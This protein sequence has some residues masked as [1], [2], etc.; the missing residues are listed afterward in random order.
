MLGWE[1]WSAQTQLVLNHGVLTSVTTVVAP[2]ITLAY[3]LVETGST[4]NA[5]ASLNLTLVAPQLSLATCSLVVLVLSAKVVP[6][7]FPN[8][9]LTTVRTGELCQSKPTL[10]EPEFG[11]EWTTYTTTVQTQ[12]LQR[13]SSSSS[14]PP[15]GTLKSLT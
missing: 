10:L 2:A 11:V 12:L 4:M 8:V 3:R 9:T 15:V 6:P 7:M 13:V 14:S 5:G 1:D